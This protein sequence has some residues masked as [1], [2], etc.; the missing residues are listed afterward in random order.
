MGE[1]LKQIYDHDS[2]NDAWV[3]AQKE[4]KR[5][6]CIVSGSYGPNS[7]GNVQICLPSDYDRE[8]GMMVIRQYRLC[9]SKVKAEYVFVPCPSCLTLES[10]D[11]TKA[12]QVNPVQTGLDQMVPDFPTRL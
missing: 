10:R 2:R 9:F 5:I 8:T 11:I 6:K 12:S 7:Y 1:H 4:G 3:K